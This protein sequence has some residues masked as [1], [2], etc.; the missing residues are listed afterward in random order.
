MYVGLY[1]E[2]TACACLCMKEKSKHMRIP[3]S[4]IANYIVSIC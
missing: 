4:V 1:K 3:R 2:K